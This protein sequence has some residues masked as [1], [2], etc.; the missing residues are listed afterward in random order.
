MSL[1]ITLAVLL[2][3]LLNVPA[4][5][6]SASDSRAATGNRSNTNRKL[7]RGNWYG[8]ARSTGT[9]GNGLRLSPSSS[10]S[11]QAGGGSAPGNIAL[12]QQG[13]GTLPPT[14]L[15]GFVKNS[16]MSDAIYGDEMDPKT[17]V[18]KYYSF[19]QSHRIETGM[20]APD[21]TTNHRI[22]GPSAWDFPK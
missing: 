13:K 21:L 12:M 5:A 19:D 22:S 16:G 15:E 7:T 9:Q 14:R 8:G 18:S 1:Q 10:S 2:V 11:P 4:Q 17:L 3:M 6:S 20:N